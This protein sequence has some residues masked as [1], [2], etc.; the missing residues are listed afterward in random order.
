MRSP[1]GQILDLGHVCG[2]AIAQPNTT[3]SGTF[4]LPIKRRDA[5][6]PVVDVTF[7]GK[8]R[9]E[10]FVDTGASATTI[11]PEMAK[12]LGIGID[13]EI[14]VATA[15]GVIQAGI[16]RVASVQAGGLVIKDVDVV[17]SPHLPIGLLGQN[18]FGGH[19]ITIRDNVIE[20]RIR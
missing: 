7:N 16:G 6:I 12:A 17:I 13:K 3:P 8:Q 5:G 2:D 11:S 20:L 10:M 14:P 4:R 19:D 1:N 15:G 9:F 18:F